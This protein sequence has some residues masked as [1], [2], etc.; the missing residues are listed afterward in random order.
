MN[1][2]TTY[3]DLVGIL[4]AQWDTYKSA[5]TQALAKVGYDNSGVYKGLPVI[6]QK[7]PCLGVMPANSIHTPAGN[8][9][10]EE[11]DFALDIYFYAF[12]FNKETQITKVLQMSNT[13]EAIV[14][15]YREL[16]AVVDVCRIS[17][18]EYGELIRQSFSGGQFRAA[19]GIATVQLTD[20]SSH[21]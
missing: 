9:Y 15:H 12:D 16:N 14:A 5:A 17:R 20:K 10:L 21:I 4:G 11:V 1:K 18:V 19:G 8:Q 6:V 2:L 7:M 13:I 3:N